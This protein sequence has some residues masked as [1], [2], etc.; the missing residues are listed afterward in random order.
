MQWSVSCIDHQKQ[1]VNDAEYVSGLNVTN[2]VAN[3]CLNLYMPATVAKQEAALAFPTGP[4]EEL[5]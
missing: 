2:S 1:P 4:C 5:A 3:I